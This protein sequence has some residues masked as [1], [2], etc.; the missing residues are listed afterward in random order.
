MTDAQT[1]TLSPFRP[2]QQ[3]ANL[4]STLVARLTEEITSGRL[5]PGL[6]L[7]TEKEMMV[8]FGVS[9]TVIREAVSALRADGLVVTRQGSGAFV[10]DGGRR[11]FRIDPDQLDS[12][13]DVLNL[14]EL[15]T[16]VELEAAGLAAGRR[17]A[18]DLRGIEEAL[19]RIDRAIAEGDPAINAD[20]DFHRAIARATHNP[21][22][23][24]FLEFL[25]NLTIPRQSVRIAVQTPEE[26][27]AYLNRVQTEHRDIYAA[28][29]GQDA[30]A[31]REAA[32]R[33]FKNSRTRYQKIAEEVAT[34][35][36][37]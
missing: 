17:K 3:P 13:R 23:L 36:L 18:E 4:T 30:D 22:H 14:M 11:P 31:A 16:S 35:E 15:R 1:V 28:I 7:P 19:D 10:A 25:G 9:R 21:Y 12:I 34:R 6:R 5:V 24:K 32:R 29:K 8:S 2:L 33:H 26:Q 37:D 27:R 20:F